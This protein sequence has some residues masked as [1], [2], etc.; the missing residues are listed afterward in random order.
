LQI[1]EVHADRRIGR[2]NGW[3]HGVP[4]LTKQFNT[5][6]GLDVAAA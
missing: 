5:I 3:E 2:S 1:A 4:A 6:T